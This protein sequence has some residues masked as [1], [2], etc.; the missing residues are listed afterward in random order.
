[1]DKA[2][3]VGK[4]GMVKEENQGG[5]AMTPIRETQAEKGALLT[6]PKRRELHPYPKGHKRKLEEEV[7]SL[8]SIIIINYTVQSCMNDNY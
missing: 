4:E 3:F 2:F 5:L 7:N 1:M 6:V 8:D